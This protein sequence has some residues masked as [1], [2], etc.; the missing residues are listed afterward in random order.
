MHARLK[1]FA[2]LIDSVKSFNDRESS[3]EIQRKHILEEKLNL[4]IKPES[5]LRR[6]KAKIMGCQLVVQTKL[7]PP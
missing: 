3:T 4:D 7:K 2:P 6:S 1:N 5:L